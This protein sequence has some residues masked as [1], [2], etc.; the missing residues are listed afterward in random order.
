MTEPRRTQQRSGK[1]N[2]KVITVRKPSLSPA[3]NTEEIEVPDDELQDGGVL[4]FVAREE[5]EENPFS[6]KEE[7]FSV[8]ET[9]YESYVRVPASWGLQYLRLGL[10]RGPDFAAIYAMEQAMGVAAVNALTE[11]PDMTA[12]QLDSIIKKITQKFVAATSVPKGE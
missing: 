12:E 10:L 11:I 5:S 2:M 4:R 3:E 1:P 9:R 8:G 6:E 7:V